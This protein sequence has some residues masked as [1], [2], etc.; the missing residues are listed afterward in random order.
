[1]SH[2]HLGTPPPS[3]TGTPR[4]QSL[5]SQIPGGESSVI[6]WGGNGPKNAFLISL[7][8]SIQMLAF[9]LATPPPPQTA[10]TFFSFLALVTVFCRI[11]AL[12]YVSC[13]HRNSF[14]RF[15][16]L[17]KVSASRG[18]CPHTF[19]TKIQSDSLNP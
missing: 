2:T 9:K 8:I 10:P 3:V 12:S 19:V 1:M 5:P 7:S 4:A 14:L 13:V 6:G 18:F 16:T 17:E 11:Q 15:P